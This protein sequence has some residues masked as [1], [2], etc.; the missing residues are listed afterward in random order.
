MKS[1]I[2]LVLIAM[3]VTAI[4]FLLGVGWQLAT[5]WLS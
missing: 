2:E 1:L 5:Q 3:V 4:G